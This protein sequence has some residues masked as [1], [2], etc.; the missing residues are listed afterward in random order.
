MSGGGNAVARVGQDGASQQRGGLEG[1]L[2]R[3]GWP[4][5]RSSPASEWRHERLAYGIVVRLQ[6]AAAARGGFMTAVSVGL[7]PPDPAFCVTSPSPGAV[8]GGRDELMD[9]VLSMVG[10]KGLAALSSKCA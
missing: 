4:R 2:H 1:T 5:G 9:D 8:R 7:D 3:W 6:T 10:G